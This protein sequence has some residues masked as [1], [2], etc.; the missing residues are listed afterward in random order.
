MFSLYGSKLHERPS[1]CRQPVAR[2]R[3]NAP[4]PVGICPRRRLL[5]EDEAPGPR[6][7]GACALRLRGY[8]VIEAD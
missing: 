7:C 2:P 1:S 5:V 8:T 6:L 3:G 4:P